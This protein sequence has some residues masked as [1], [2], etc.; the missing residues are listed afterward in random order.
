MPIARRSSQATLPAQT[1]GVHRAASGDIDFD[2]VFSPSPKPAR[3]SRV[4][5]AVRP[6]EPVM[7]VPL[8]ELEGPKP[9]R[10]TQMQAVRPVV[11]E[12]EP[13]PGRMLDDVFLD[14]DGAPLALDLQSPPSGHL[15]L[16]TVAGESLP[17]MWAKSGSGLHPHTA[18][19]KDPRPGIVA[20][21]GYGIPPEKLAAMPSYAFRVIARKHSLRSDL[22]I[23]RLRRLPQRDIELYE[24]ALACANQG[25]VAKGLAITAAM[26]AGTVSAIAA[27]VAL[28]F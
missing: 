16:Q 19:S 18:A 23:A 14:D 21:A 12:P 20:F 24:A 4:M 6:A 26:F 22:K 2:D 17:A 27:A 25:A 28:L 11:A 5:A 7:G 15:P 1:S 10:S 9:A 8:P 3:S 13:P